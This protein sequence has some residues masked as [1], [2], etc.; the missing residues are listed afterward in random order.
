MSFDVIQDPSCEASSLENEKKARLRLHLPFYSYKSG[1][2]SGI[3]PVYTW[4]GNV[5]TEHI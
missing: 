4:L 2:F 5:Q 3:F 1:N